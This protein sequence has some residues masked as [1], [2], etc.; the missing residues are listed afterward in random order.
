MENYYQQTFDMGQVKILNVFKWEWTV[1][2]RLVSK[3][4]KTLNVTFKVGSNS[5]DFSCIVFDYR[6]FSRLRDMGSI[7]EIFLSIIF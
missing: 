4:F 3:I 1:D 6:G 5:G 2:E 7:L